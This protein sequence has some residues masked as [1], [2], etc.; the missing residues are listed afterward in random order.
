M[1][2]GVCPCRYLVLLVYRLDTAFADKSGKQR[3]GCGAMGMRMRMRAR[4]VVRVARFEQRRWLALLAAWLGHG[5]GLNVLW[6]GGADVTE[7]ACGAA[8]VVGARREL[9]GEDA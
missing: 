1:F 2:D 7:R 6:V 5:V 9:P 4:S 8:A 3:H